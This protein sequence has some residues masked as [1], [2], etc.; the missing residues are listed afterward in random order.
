MTARTSSIAK[1]RQE[2]APFDLYITPYPLA[3]AICRWLEANKVALNLRADYILEPSAGYGDFVRA[4]REV[5]PNA[6]IHANEVQ[7]KLVPREEMRAYLVEYARVKKGAGKVE[8]DALPLPIAT[9]DTHAVLK[10][11]GA[12]A[13]S[14]ADFLGSASDFK[15]DL[16]QANP[17][18]SLGG[19][20]EA[21]V[22]HSLKMLQPWGL[23]SQLLKMHFRGTAARVGFW[24]ENKLKADPPIVPRPNFTGDGRDTVEYTNYV[25][26]AP[27]DTGTNSIHCADAICWKEGA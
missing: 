21:H 19:G 4:A 16:I 25:W 11:A 22:R 23:S 5:W 20:A 12:T 9:L 14:T 1:T 3:L 8:A 26:G 6:Y 7:E 18:Y 15:F 27:P 10:A 17:P 24:K 2:R 13:T